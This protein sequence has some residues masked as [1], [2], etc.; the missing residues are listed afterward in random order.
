MNEMPWMTPEFRQQM[1]AS[2]QR[3]LA[4]LHRLHAERGGDCDV[5]EHWSIPALEGRRMA[6]EGCRKHDILISR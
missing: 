1:A 3:T 2:R 6:V 5:W 4:V